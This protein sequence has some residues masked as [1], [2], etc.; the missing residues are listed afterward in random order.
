MHTPGRN[1]SFSFQA[2][3]WDLVRVLFRH[4]PGVASGGGRGEVP[5]NDATTRALPAP[6]DSGV[7]MSEVGEAGDPMEEEG[8]KEAEDP[9]AGPQA[10]VAGATEVD[11][12]AETGSDA[13]A[14]GAW[15]AMFQRRSQL[16]GWLRAHAR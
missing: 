1:L 15:L 8:P 11:D 14:G 5:S 6:S 13:A 10:E 7:A 16:A 2:D 12:D 4:I 3:T 9:E